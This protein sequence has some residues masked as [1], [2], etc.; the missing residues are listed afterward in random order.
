[1]AGDVTTTPA[2]V[3]SVPVH[4]ARAIGAHEPGSMTSRRPLQSHGGAA[5]RWRRRRVIG[6]G[7]CAAGLAGIAVVLIPR[8]S[9]DSDTPFPLVII[10]TLAGALVGDGVHRIVSSM[11]MAR[12]R[13]AASS[14]DDT[15]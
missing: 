15:E 9:S 2:Y 14:A 1:M 3:G 8:L 12:R 5:Q 11:R 13:A 4:L 7:M 6:I 10:A